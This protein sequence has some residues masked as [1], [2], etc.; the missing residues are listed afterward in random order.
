MHTSF[1]V[2][3]KDQHSIRILSRTKL[4]VLPCKGMPAKYMT[5]GAGPKICTPRL[6]KTTR[7]PFCV[8]YAY[9]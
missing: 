5:L 7:A 9:F 1:R 3:H 4:N 2:G 8:A 6:C